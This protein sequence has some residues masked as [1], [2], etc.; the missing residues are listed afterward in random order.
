MRKF[1]SEK[2]WYFAIVFLSFVITPI[3]ERVMIYY[4]DEE[5]I[6]TI[7]N[8]SFRI[9]DVLPWSAAGVVFLVCLGV[10]IYQLRQRKAMDVS[11]NHMDYLNGVLKKIINEY[12][13]VESIQAFQFWPKN[14]NKRKYI[15]LSYLTGIANEGIEINTILQTYYYF[16]YSMYK[17]ITT[18]SGHY[19]NYISEKDPVRKENAQTA[20]LNSGKE[21]CE[22]L[23]NS[24]NKIQSI[25]EIGDFHCE[26]YRVLARLLTAIS[27]KAIESFLNNQEVELALIKRKKSGILGAVILDDLYIFRNQNSLGKRERIYFT[28]PY[29]KKL[30]IIL[31]A[32]INGSC[33]PSDQEG[34][35]ENYCKHVMLS[36]FV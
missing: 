30:K 4:F 11:S 14:D 3:F 1:L 20:F 5:K 34:N 26:M 28:F 18:V 19:S 13:Y 9:A 27:G 8:T 16:T 23:L 22:S 33:F 7:L 6:D 24:L 29:D 15:K 25:D 2:P 32:A 35:I 12:E 31:L 36:A 21:L 10:Y 17:K